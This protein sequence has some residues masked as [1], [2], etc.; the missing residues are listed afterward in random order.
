MDRRYPP[1]MPNHGG[2]SVSVPQNLP[3]L[4]ATMPLCCN[5]IV[6][7]RLERMTDQQLLELRLRDLPVQVHG[8]RLVPRLVRVYEELYSRDL[9]F[10]PHVWLSEE[11]F[12]P[13]G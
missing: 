13:D 4:V 1:N 3:P 11:W 5:R 2:P 6:N 8:T 12:T 7:S 10:A 9:L